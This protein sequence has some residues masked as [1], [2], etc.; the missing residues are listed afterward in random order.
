MGNG[1]GRIGGH[2]RAAEVG[3]TPFEKKARSS[4]FEIRISDF[5]CSRGVT[6]TRLEVETQDFASLPAVP[7]FCQRLLG[8][9]A[10]QFSAA[11]RQ[12]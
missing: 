10:H 5:L 4:N 9:E 2:V 3:W 11:G 12:D 1:L 6:D 7:S 8:G